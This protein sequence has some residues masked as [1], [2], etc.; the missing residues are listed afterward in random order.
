MNRFTTN[1]KPLQEHCQAQEAE[2]YPCKFE[3]EC[4][5]ENKFN[6]K[7][8]A[9]NHGGGVGC[10]VWRAKTNRKIGERRLPGDA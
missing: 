1:F 9:C 3:F 5:R 10:K 6:P 7:N 2:K 4:K 8:Y